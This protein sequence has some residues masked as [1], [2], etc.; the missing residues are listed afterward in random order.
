MRLTDSF[1]DLLPRELIQREKWLMQK[2]WMRQTTYVRFFVIA[3]CLVLGVFDYFVD[4]LP[5]SWEL[6]NELNLLALFGN[7]LSVVAL[8]R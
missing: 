1:S 4:V 2:E 8:R 3:L 7:V 5:A 6:F